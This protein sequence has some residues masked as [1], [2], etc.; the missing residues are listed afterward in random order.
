[1]EYEEIELIKKSENGEVQLIKEKGGENFYIRKI[2]KGKVP[3]YGIL[4]DCQHPCLPKIY[5]V[6][7]TDDTTTIIEEYIEGQSLGRVE[8]TGKKFWNIVRDLCSVLQFLHDM[9]VIHRDIKP[10]NIIYAEDEHIRLIDFGAARVL[11]DEQEQDTRLLG[12]RGYAPPEQYGFSQTDVRT[13]IYSLGVTLEQILQN[14][15]QRFQYKKVIRKCMDLNPDKRYQSARQVKRAFFQAKHKLLYALSM[16]IVIVFLCGY[17]WTGNVI[18]PEP[19]INEKSENSEKTENSKETEEVEN[20]GG[21]ERYPNQIL[22]N[23]Y[24]VREYM[25]RYID[26]IMDEID[27]PYDEYI[28]DGEEAM[29]A[30]RDIGIIFC[31][32]DKRKVDLIAID[33]EMSTFN[34]ESLNVNKEKLIELLGAPIYATWKANN[35]VYYIDYYDIDT[36]E[37]TT[38]YMYSPEEAPYVIYMD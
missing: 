32:D 34:G 28:D 9:D 21:P 25:G 4:K 17:I 29:C 37:G 33:P 11:K 8:L 19:V 18:A 6:T 10:S 35:E 14:K 26:D 23:D 7:V 38:F 15:I 5:E 20:S 30:Y 12:T 31:F 2:I 13:D 36:K 3:A 22:C 24:P 16:L 27:V 1:M